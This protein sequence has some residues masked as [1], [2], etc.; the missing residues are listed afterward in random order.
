[1]HVFL[2]EIIPEMVSIE[3]RIAYSRYIELKELKIHLIHV[4]LI[5]GGVLSYHGSLAK[6]DT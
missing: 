1:M 3:I 6:H 5:K 2:S 4:L